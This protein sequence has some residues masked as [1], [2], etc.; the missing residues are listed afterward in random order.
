MKLN[1]YEMLSKRMYLAYFQFMLSKI[2][3]CCEQGYE[4]DAKK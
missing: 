1:L 2:R 3:N 4:F